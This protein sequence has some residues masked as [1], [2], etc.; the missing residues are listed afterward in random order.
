MT[1]DPTPCASSDDRSGVE[2]RKPWMTPTIEDADV[3][4]VTNGSGT[5]GVEGTFFLKPGS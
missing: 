2:Q 3:A 5:S 4:A 1:P